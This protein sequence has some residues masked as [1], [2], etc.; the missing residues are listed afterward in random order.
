MV[1]LFEQEAAI[2]RDILKDELVDIHHIGSTAVPYL[3]AKPI[4][5]IMPV[6]KDIARVDEYN[7]E[8]INVGYEPLSEFGIRGR[9]YFRKGGVNR[10]HHMHMFQFDNTHQIERHLAVRDYL[11][12][13]QED[14]IAYGEWKQQLAALY[15]TDNESYCDGKDEFVVHLERRA[16]EWKNILTD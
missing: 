9:R 1:A 6:V 16:L 11:R 12:T 3:K 15:P 14:R 7:D 2:L 8:L 10:T 5:D 13:H 4:I